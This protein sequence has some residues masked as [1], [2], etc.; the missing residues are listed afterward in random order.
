MNDSNGSEGA[1]RDQLSRLHQASGGK[2]EEYVLRSRR[3][4]KYSLLFPLPQGASASYIEL[5]SNPMPSF[6]YIS[7]EV[8]KPVS[9]VDSKG[10]VIYES[11][12]WVEDE[13]GTFEVQA[14]FTLRNSDIVVAATMNESYAGIRDAIRLARFTM[15]V[16][17]AILAVFGFAFALWVMEVNL[18]GTMNKS[19]GI[20]KRLVDRDYSV[21]VQKTPRDDELGNILNILHEFVGI[22]KENELVSVEAQRSQYAL[23]DASTAVIVLD[24]K[25]HVLSINQQGSTL[26]NEHASTTV[27]CCHRWILIIPWTPSLILS[28]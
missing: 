12:D 4:L 5:V 2:S 11:P 9:V 17:F 8:G 21:D 24:K 25:G 14:E 20:M 18:F 28:I 6:K 15:P 23:N 7:D 22:F 26:L 27:R 10:V 1:S 3:E 13:D 16:L 19:A